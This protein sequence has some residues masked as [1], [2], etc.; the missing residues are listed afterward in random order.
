MQA[1]SLLPKPPGFFH[2]L[3]ELNQ[4][5]PCHSS[6]WAVRKARDL[7][8]L[9]MVQKERLN[10]SSTLCYIH[11]QNYGPR[12]NPRSGL[13]ESGA[14]LIVLS[15][16]ITLSYIFRVLFSFLSAWFKRSDS[17]KLCKWAKEDDLGEAVQ[18]LFRTY[19]YHPPQHTHT[20]T[21]THTKA[22][23]T[24]FTDHI[25]LPLGVPSYLFFEQAYYLFARY[26]CT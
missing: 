12:G 2:R 20:H 5:T 7:W 4:Y 18:K 25:N 21:H 13:R 24:R 15:L 3:L 1:D 22:N 8:R 26:L 10:V 19:R 9:P 17:A 14:C 6:L 11:P 16:L 23:N